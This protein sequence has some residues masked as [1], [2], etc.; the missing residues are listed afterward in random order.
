MKIFSRAG[1][2]LFVTCFMVTSCALVKLKKDL[3]QGQASTVLVGRVST[4]FPG[5]GPIVVAA[6]P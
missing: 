2:I 4:E 5:K 6:W 1:V 3:S